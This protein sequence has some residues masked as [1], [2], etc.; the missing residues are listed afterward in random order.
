MSINKKILLFLFALTI[1]WWVGFLLFAYKI[2]HFN[3]LSASHTDAIIVLTGGKNRINEAIS[4]LDKGWSD[5]LFI[6]GVSKKTTLSSLRQRR[7]ISPRVQDK[8]TLEKNSTNTVENAIETTDWIHKNN[9]HSIR[10]V[11][12][13][14]HLLRSEQE[15]RA[16]NKHLKII[17]HP[18]YSENV[19]PKWWKN[20][21]SFCLVASEYNKFLI[22]WVRNHLSWIYNKK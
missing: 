17:L 11:T 3:S 13:N 12:S 5:K 19:S 9:I 18:V 14:Y 1:L 8:I 2:N 4:L 6:S 10:L 7:Y 15:F 16:Q 20:I 21:G 22:V